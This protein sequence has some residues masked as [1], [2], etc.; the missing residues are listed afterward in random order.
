MRRY[1]RT[2]R[3]DFRWPGSL[4]A[5]GGGPGAWPALL[6]HNVGLLVAQDPRPGISRHTHILQCRLGE[7]TEGNNDMGMWL[8][9]GGGPI[10]IKMPPVAA[11]YGEF[12][13]RCR[14]VGAGAE[15]ALA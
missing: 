4:I 2:I 3:E 7:I 1:T 8:N 13:D 5:E 12:V 10:E 9:D 11:S 14:E 15:G 6:A